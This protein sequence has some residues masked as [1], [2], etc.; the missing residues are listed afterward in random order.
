M[1]FLKTENGRVTLNINGEI[2]NFS[3]INKAIKY[4]VN[5]RNRKSKEAQAG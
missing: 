2:K 3:S 5:R 4:L 1:V